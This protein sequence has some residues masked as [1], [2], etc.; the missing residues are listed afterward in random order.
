MLRNMVAGIR[1]GL[2][3]L[4]T[5]L[6]K[7]RHMRP[8]GTT[9]VPR[10]LTDTSPRLAAPQPS[11]KLRLGGATYRKMRRLRIMQRL[12]RRKVTNRSKS[13]IRALQRKATVDNNR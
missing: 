7:D 5:K 8:A 12:A 11:R 3:Q 9:S 13:R 4:K 10:L 2:G 6:K 1:T